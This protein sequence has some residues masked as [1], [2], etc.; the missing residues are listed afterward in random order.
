M[1]CVLPS[2]LAAAHLFQSPDGSMGCRPAP[3][4]ALLLPAPTK[5]GAA[6]RSAGLQ[7]TSRGDHAGWMRW[8]PRSRWLQQRADGRRRRRRQGRRVAQCPTCRSAGHARPQL[9]A[10]SDAVASATIQTPTGSG[11]LLVPRQAHACQNNYTAALAVARPA[12]ASLAS[13][14]NLSALTATQQMRRNRPGCLG[15]HR[16]TIPCGCHWQRHVQERHAAAESFW[17]A[18][19]QSRQSRHYRA[20]ATLPQSIFARCR[21][22]LALQPSPQV[23]AE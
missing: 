13:E 22:R 14:P 7:G 20:G 16:V 11:I 4:P 1:P 12:A 19:A 18:I 3:Q 17:D 23:P 2:L 10:C 5:T 8:G 21:G 15:S 9:A 6:G